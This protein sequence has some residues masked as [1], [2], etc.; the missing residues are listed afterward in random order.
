[1]KKLAGLCV[2]ACLCVCGGAVVAQ[3]GMSEAQMPPPKVLVIER[4]MIKPGRSGAIHEK[5]ELAFVNAAKAA[6]WETH[7][8]A[9]TSL[10]GQPRAIFLF[11][12]PSFEAWEKDNAAVDKNAVFSAAIDKASMADGELQTQYQQSVFTLNPES[13]LRAVDAVHARYFEI[14]QFRVKPGH[15]QE[16]MELVKLYRNAYEKAAPAAHWA[17]YDSYY[18]ENNGG[19]YLIITPMKSLSED[20][21][22][23]GDSKKVEETLGPDGMKRVA[24]LTA[25]CLES[26]ESNLFQISPKMSYPAAEWI[27]ADSFWAPKTMTAPMKKAPAATP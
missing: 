4:E 26:S 21:Q 16:W 20:D 1:M 11:G 23:M 6:K 13:S 10:S 2:V 27:K 3:D 15:R 8:V 24:E 18:G 19:Y 5:S 22:S 25:A 9:A 14:T 17:F 12:Y 7:Y